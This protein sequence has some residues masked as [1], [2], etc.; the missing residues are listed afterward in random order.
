MGHQKG[1]TMVGGDSLPWGRTKQLYASDRLPLPSRGLL[2]LGEWRETPVQ[3][4][5]RVWL[6]Q[7]G[8]AG[9]LKN[10]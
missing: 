8:E 3:V 10:T 2:L 5:G 6:S 9:M 4:N 7:G 1:Q